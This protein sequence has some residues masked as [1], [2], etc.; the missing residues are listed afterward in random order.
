MA[1]RTVC[2]EDPETGK[3]AFELR[4]Y[5]VRLGRW[6]TVDPYSQFYSPYLGMGNTPIIAIDSDGG[7]ITLITGGIGALI[8]AGINI[9]SQYKAGEL[10]WSSE[11]SRKSSSGCWWWVCC[12]CNRFRRVAVAANTVGDFTDQL[13]KNDGDFS[14]V[15]YTKTLTAGATTFVGGKLILEK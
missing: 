6:L 8:N 4:L 3:P 12:W 15:N 10:E 13:I 14:K 1:I 5:D 7:W 11:K 9:Y 2:R